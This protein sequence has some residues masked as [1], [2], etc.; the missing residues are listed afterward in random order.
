MRLFRRKR[1]HY[2]YTVLAY[3]YDFNCETARKSPDFRPEIAD[4]SADTPCPP[5]L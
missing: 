1:A 3:Q 2:R 5:K 4:P